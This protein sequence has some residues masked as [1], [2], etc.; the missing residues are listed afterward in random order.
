[1]AAQAPLTTRDIRSNTLH[2]DG[3]VVCQVHTYTSAA[4][5]AVEDRRAHAEAV[6]LDVEA[7]LS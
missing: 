2:V 3:K 5:G 4:L 7:S 6:V 1:M